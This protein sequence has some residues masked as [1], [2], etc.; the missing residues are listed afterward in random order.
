MNT[1][2]RSHY[3]CAIA[4]GVA[5]AWMVIGAIILYLVERV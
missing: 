5:L 2:D 3:I 1:P 4:V